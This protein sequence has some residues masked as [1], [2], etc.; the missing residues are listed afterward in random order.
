[1]EIESDIAIAFLDVLV[2]RE[3]TTMATKVYRKP[4]HTGRYLSFNSNH[5]PHVNRGLVLSLHNRASARCQ[6]RQ[7]LFNET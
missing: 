6:E 7:Y 1:M 2:I 3:E 4:T 5:P